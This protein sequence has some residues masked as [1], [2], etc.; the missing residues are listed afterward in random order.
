MFAD[1]EYIDD[2]ETM[3]ESADPSEGDEA[4]DAG[5]GDTASANN[6]DGAAS[7]PNPGEIK[8]DDKGAK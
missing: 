5:N 6:R 1:F 4:A 3:E 8:E 7:D 2:N